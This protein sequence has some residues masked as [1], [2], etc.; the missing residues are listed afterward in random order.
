MPG[1]NDRGVIVCTPAPG[2]LKAIKSGPGCALALVIAPRSEQVTGLHSV[3]SSVV[4][5]TMAFAGGSL[6]MIVRVA[7]TGLPSV[8]FVGLLRLRFTVLLP[9]T[10]RLSI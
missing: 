5:T 3:P 4:L 8:A 2:M 1:R 10:I 6:S 7:A 9:S